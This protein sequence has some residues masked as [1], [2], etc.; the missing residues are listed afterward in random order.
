MAPLENLA[1]AAL[2]EVPVAVNNSPLGCPQ[3][4]S[5]LAPHRGQG[6]RYTRGGSCSAGADATGSPAYRSNRVLFPVATIVTRRA[7]PKLSM[8]STPFL[9]RCRSEL[10]ENLLPPWPMARSCASVGQGSFASAAATIAASSAS[11]FPDSCLAMGMTKYRHAG[12]GF[13]YES[14]FPST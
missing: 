13:R 9:T 10:L 2:P 4:T 1:V 11:L 12:L 14:R 7:F 6:S 8:V 5:P 3:S